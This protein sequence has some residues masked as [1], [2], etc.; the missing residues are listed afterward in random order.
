M[1]PRKRSSKVSTEDLMETI[2]QLRDELRGMS[3]ENRGL[4]AELTRLEDEKARETKL[5][6]LSFFLFLSFLLHFSS[7]SILFATE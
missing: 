1:D 4:R 6:S 7:I 5:F 3:E 2:F